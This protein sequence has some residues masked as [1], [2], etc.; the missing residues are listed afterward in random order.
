MYIKETWFD[1]EIPNRAFW[2]PQIF[3]CKFATQINCFFHRSANDGIKYNRTNLRQYTREDDE[4]FEDDARYMRSRYPDWPDRYKIVRLDGLD[5]FFKEISFDYKTK[6]WQNSNE[7]SMR[8]DRKN[9]K[10]V[11]PRNKLK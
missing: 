11:I 4:I 1:D 6:T 10:F 7:F 3:D 5:D 8:W 9:Y 2:V